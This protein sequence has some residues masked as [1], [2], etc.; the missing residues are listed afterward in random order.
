MIDA[1]SRRSA[2]APA[3]A[4]TSRAPAMRGPAGSAR[5]S[6][7]VPERVANKGHGEPAAA[8][9]DGAPAGASHVIEGALTTLTE[10]RRQLDD[11]VQR[12]MRGEEMSAKELLGWQC[13][14]YAYSQQ[15]EF[16]S[17][18]V[19]RSVSALKTLLNTNL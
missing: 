19:D 14:L 4:Q 16:A 12:A 5:F 15:V 1:V 8:R 11:L 7:D 3:N 2:P 13:R 6:L 10:Q 9:A 18:A 17:R